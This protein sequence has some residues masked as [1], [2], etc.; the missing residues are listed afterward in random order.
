MSLL[1]WVKPRHPPRL[2]EPP[3]APPGTVCAL[4][5]RL[6]FNTAETVKKHTLS[7]KATIAFVCICEVRDS[8]LTG[9]SRNS[10]DESNSQITR[11][12]MV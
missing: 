9:E 2:S 11:E 12:Q 6:A 1:V 3:Q 5:W 8:W 4:V 10:R 7:L